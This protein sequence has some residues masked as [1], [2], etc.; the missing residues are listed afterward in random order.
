MKYF[1][2]IKKLRIKNVDCDFLKYNIIKDFNK[3]SNGS[4][5]KIPIDYFEN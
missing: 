1:Y 2:Q 5:S 4:Q 3:I